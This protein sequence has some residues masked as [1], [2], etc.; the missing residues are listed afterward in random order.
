MKSRFILV[1]KSSN[2]MNCNL[3]GGLKAVIVAATINNNVICVNVAGR[4]A[5]K[6]FWKPPGK[7]LSTGFIKPVDPLHILR[8]NTRTCYGCLEDFRMPVGMPV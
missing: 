6:L 4:L 1:I 5:G 3:V 8:I 2:A 7:H